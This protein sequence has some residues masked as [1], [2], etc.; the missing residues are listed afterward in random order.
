VSREQIIVPPENS[1][2]LAAGR[3]GRERARP[4]ECTGAEECYVEIGALGLVQRQ[5]K[6]DIC[7]ACRGRLID[8][9]HHFGPVR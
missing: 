9:R 4:R 2:L 8:Y 6:R 1:K 5:L 3:P 7:A